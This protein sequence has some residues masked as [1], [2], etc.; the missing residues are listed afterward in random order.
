MGP[1]F[2]EMQL[3]SKFNEGFRFSLYITA[4][5]SKHAWLV[6]FRNKKGITITNYIQKILNGSGCK[7]NKIWADKGS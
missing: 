6:P 3:I 4:I 2:T 7:P 1:D 5:C